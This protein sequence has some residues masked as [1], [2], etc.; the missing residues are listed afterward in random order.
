MGDDEGARLVMYADARAAT[1]VVTQM[2][3]IAALSDVGIPGNNDLSG[4]MMTQYSLKEG[5]KR[6]GEQGT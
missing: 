1:E 4:L 5:L 3:D 2:F 6:L